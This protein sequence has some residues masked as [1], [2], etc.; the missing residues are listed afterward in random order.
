MT[1]PIQLHRIEILIEELEKLRQR[2]KE[3]KEEIEFNMGFWITPEMEGPNLKGKIDKAVRNPCGT[4]A[5]LA[6]KAGLIPRIRRLGFKF[7]IVPGS[8][9]AKA[10]FQYTENGFNYRENSAIGAFFGE[11]VTKK[12]FIGSHNIDTLFQGIQALKR[13]VRVRS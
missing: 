10:E 9:G 12:I 3:R 5:C 8:Y 11:D 2:A 7:D 1:T 6:G 4:A 13:F